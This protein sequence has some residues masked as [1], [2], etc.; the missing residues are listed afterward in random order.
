VEQCQFDTIYHEHVY[1]FSV[2]SLVAILAQHTL[3][4]QQ[5]EEIPIHGGSLRSVIGFDNDEGA[6]VR[7]MLAAEAALGVNRSETYQLFASQCAQRSAQLRTLVEK[8][9]DEGARIAAFG[10]AAK[11]CTLLHAAGLG[12][13]H[14]EFVVDNNRHK[15]GKFLP[16]SHLPIHAPAV[17]RQRQPDYTLLLSWNFADE[18][19]EQEASYLAAGGR[20]ISPVPEPRII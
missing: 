6:S 20:F 1:Y 5:V 10:A 18:I 9:K 8:L 4:L 17:L 16:G 3:V 15:Q 7:A 13:D 2:T 12:A 14:I 11:G 19:L